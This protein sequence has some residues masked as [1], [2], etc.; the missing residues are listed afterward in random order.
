MDDSIRNYCGVLI[1]FM[2]E[3]D[4]FLSA[5]DTANDRLF[6]SYDIN[7]E[8]ILNKLWEKNII[9]KET[10]DFKSEDGKTLFKENVYFI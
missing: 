6:N 4:N 10:R 7:M 8:E 3:K 9:K 1:D 5:E 2:N